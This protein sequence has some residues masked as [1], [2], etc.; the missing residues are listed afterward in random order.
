MIM[1]F[2]DEKIH[3][4]QKKFEYLVDRLCQTKSAIAE[5][6]LEKQQNV[7]TRIDKKDAE[8]R[9]QSGKLF[10]LLLDQQQPEETENSNT[11]YLVVEHGISVLHPIRRLEV[12]IRRLKTKLDDYREEIEWHEENFFT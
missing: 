12:E 8:L 9:V 6:I 4:W 1:I 7:I 10:R 2:S 11:F 5:I 3:T